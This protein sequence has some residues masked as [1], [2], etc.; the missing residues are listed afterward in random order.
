MT[1][2]K[3]NLTFIWCAQVLSLSG[4]GFVIPFLPT[5]AIGGVEPNVQSALSAKTERDR[6]GLLFGIQTL[7]G[8]AGW[9]FGPLVGGF[10]STSA[11]E[12]CSR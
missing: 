9:V 7:V 10:H 12:A 5:F 3:R 11:S 8:N 6:R 2:W 1:Y 4:F